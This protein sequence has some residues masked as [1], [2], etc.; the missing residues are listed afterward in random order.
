MM[1]DYTYRSYDENYV[2]QVKENM[3]D[4]LQYACLDNN[5]N[6]D[7]F[8]K[9]FLDSGL[10]RKIEIGDI[11]TIAGKSGIELADLV[12]VSCGLK[13]EFEPVWNGDYSIY[14]WAGYILAEYQ[15]YTSKRFEDIWKHMSIRKLLLKYEK[16]HQINT[17]YA[18]EEIDE[19]VNDKNKIPLNQL[20]VAKGLTQKEL[21]KRASMNIS[22]IQR[23]EYG[24]RKVENLTL[25][26]AI[27]LAK[28]LGVSVND[29]A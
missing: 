6:P 28:A 24:E 22:Q 19:M 14:Y 17:M 23:L 8:F 10:A 5:Y 1:K 20:R 26:S 25:K 15:W 18:L 4:M 7:T 13:A 16:L 21:A 3:G 27:N 29:I 12:L 2:K 9:M 11:A